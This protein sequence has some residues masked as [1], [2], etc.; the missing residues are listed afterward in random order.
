MFAQVEQTFSK[1]GPRLTKPKPISLTTKNFK[2]TNT[3]YYYDTRRTDKFGRHQIKVAISKNRKTAFLTTGIW[4]APENWDTKSEAIYG[5]TGS[6]QDNAVISSIMSNAMAVI[7]DLRLSGQLAGMDAMSI[8]DKAM[9]RI[10]PEKAQKKKVVSFTGIFKKFMDT[11]RKPGTIKTY[12]TTWNHLHNYDPNIDALTFEKITVQ[13][14]TEFES[15]LAHTANKNARNIHLRNIRAVFNYAIDQEIISFYPFRKFK[16]RPQET[17]HRALPVEQVRV[18]R[19]TPCEPH[20]EKYRDMF[21][22][23][24]Y[25]AGINA[26]DLFTP[27]HAKIRGGRIEYFRMKTQKEGSSGKFISVK[28]EPEAQEI[29]DKYYDYEK[30]IFTFMDGRADYMSFLKKMSRELKRIGT[31]ERKGYGGKKHYTPLFPEISQYWSRHTWASL[32]IEADV[33]ENTVSYALG[34][35]TR[36]A[37]TAIYIKVNQKKLDDGN[38]RVIDYINEK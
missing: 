34:H 35:D 2:M 19:D 11:K 16:I 30:G 36:I 15:Y 9:E 26:V 25:L 1:N 6:K 28:I 3:Y 32:A 38:R 18:L 13:W 29:L 37:T 22:L 7:S 4:V 31:I 23:M 10:D 12:L 8:R 20:Q 33:P 27:N 5:Y 21:I 14:L 17:A 24:I